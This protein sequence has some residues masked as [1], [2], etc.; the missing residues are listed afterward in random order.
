M[1]YLTLL[2]SLIIVSSGMA[3][4][5]KNEGFGTVTKGGEG[6]PVYRVTSL[7]DDGSPG[8]LRAALSQGSRYIVFDTSGTIIINEDLKIMDSYVTIDGATAPY[9]GITLKKSTPNIVALMIRDVSNIIISHIR[10]YGLMDKNAD[11]TQNHAG[12]IAIYT[13]DS[14]SVRNILIDHVTTR[15]AIDSGLDIWGEV[16]NVTIQYCLI[17]NSYHPQTIAYHS[18][19][20]ILKRRNISIHHNVYARN[21]ERNPQ[22]R[23]DVRTVDYVN[24][25][26]YDWGYWK[27][28]Q[29]YGIRLKNKWKPGE[30]RVTINIINN[31][32]IATRRPAWALVYGKDAGG[33]ENDEGPDKVFPQGTVYEESDMDSLYV[34]GNLLP[35]ENMDNYSTVDNPLPIPDYARVTTWPVEALADSVVPFAGTHFPLDDEQEIFDA[36]TDSLRSILKKKLNN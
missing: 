11:I 32:F 6:K 21:N 18:G 27:E 25:I 13:R 26:V 3:R 5:G 15:N 9:P 28:E 34:S 17:A 36:I 23:G 2:L 22:L 4:L 24:N 7:S 20:T 31:A 14:T 29:G 16:H 12:T 30:P 1:R 10:V 19:P 8:T 33:E 35:D